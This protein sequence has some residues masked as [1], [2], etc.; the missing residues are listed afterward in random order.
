MQSSKSSKNKKTMLTR[1]QVNTCNV[2][3]YTF[4]KTM[5]ELS[6]GGSKSFQVA[7]AVLINN[8]RDGCGRDNTDEI[9][10]QSFVKARESLVP[11]TIIIEPCQ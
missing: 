1:R 11:S 8:K 2:N 4:S 6:R 3:V 10:H 9:R 7:G 5:T